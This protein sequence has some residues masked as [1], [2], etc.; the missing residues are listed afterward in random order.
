MLTATSEN[1][2]VKFGDEINTDLSMNPP[3]FYQEWQYAFFT[4]D[5]LLWNGKR[6][7]TKGVVRPK[8]YLSATK[9]KWSMTQIEELS[10]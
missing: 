7:R 5:H 8:K 10:L 6:K 4:L 2:V 1:K 9:R 3:R